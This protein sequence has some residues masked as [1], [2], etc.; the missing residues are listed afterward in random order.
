MATPGGAAVA[1]IVRHAFIRAA[2]SIGIVEVG[3]QPAVAH[4]LGAGDAAIEGNVSALQRAAITIHVG[5][6]LPRSA[7]NRDLRAGA[8]APAQALMVRRVNVA[9]VDAATAECKRGERAK[10]RREFQ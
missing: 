5:D 1:V 4:E 7:E 10:N 6:L 3:A 2:I 8:V 9:G